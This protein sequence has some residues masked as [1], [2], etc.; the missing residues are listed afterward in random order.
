MPFVVKS[1]RLPQSPQFLSSLGLI[2]IA[3]SSALWAIAAIVASELFQA[4]VQPFELTVARAVI[5]AIGLAGMN[6]LRQSTRKR[7]ID[8]RMLS[9]GLSLAMVTVTY[10]IAIA[11]LSIAVAIVIQYSAPA[12]VVAITAL[13]ARRL[14]TRAMVA[15]VLAAIV[16]VVLV[17]GLLTGQ[18]QLDG[19]GLVAAALSALFFA[20]YTLLSEA[21]VDTYGAIG[22]MSRAFLISSLFWVAFQIS[23]GFPEAVFQAANLPGILFV[24]IGGTLI[25]FSLTC[26]GIQQVRAERGVIAATLEPLLAAIFAWL[27]LGQ[28]L[29][30]MQLLG[31]GLILAAVISLQVRSTP[32]PLQERK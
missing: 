4:G 30:V 28:T 2:A 12:L 22:V 27:W 29:S 18:L 25:P 5:A 1:F 31:G 3:V 7:L 10:Y 21:V 6:Q 14:P 13:R 32:Q 19:I 20:S 15:A 16:G 17:S 23:Q 24:G 11:R 8:W 26:W 9:L